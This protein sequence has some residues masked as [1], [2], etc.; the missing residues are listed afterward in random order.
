MYA[1]GDFFTAGGKVSAYVVGAL[2]G[3]GTSVP[4]ISQDAAFG[5]TNGMFG[6][7]VTGPAGSS[8]VVDYSTN[9]NNWIPLQTNLLGNSPLY[10]SDPQPSGGSQGFYRARLL[11]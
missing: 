9:L 10:F 8:V 2:L 11:P 7:N 5:F 6:F 3:G 4:V 1:G